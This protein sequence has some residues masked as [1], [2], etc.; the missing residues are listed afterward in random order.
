MSM[1]GIFMARVIFPLF[2]NKE[3]DKNFD[4]KLMQDRMIQ[5]AKDEINYDLDN[6]FFYSFNT[7]YV[8]Y[9]TFHD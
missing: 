1:I 9:W 2:D 4:P 8:Y 6:I 5:Q 3:V 7:Y